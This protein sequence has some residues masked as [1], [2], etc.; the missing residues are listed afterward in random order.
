M[1]GAF[2]TRL[3]PFAVASGE[4]LEAVGDKFLADEF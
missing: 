1:A 4:A 2:G 3:Y